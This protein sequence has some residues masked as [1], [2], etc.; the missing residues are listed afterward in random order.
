ML[1]AVK[2]WNMAEMCVVVTDKRDEK[3]ENAAPGGKGAVTEL[4][5]R[6]SVT[7]SEETRVANNESSPG[8]KQPN[9]G[10]SHSDADVANNKN[11]DNDHD[12]VHVHVHDN[13][14]QDASQD[15]QAHV[16]GAV[17]SLRGIID[18]VSSL[19]VDGWFQHPVSERDAPNYSAVI[20]NP[21]CFDMIRTKIGGL[22]Y[23]SWQEL[24]RDFELIFNN[25][26]LYNQKRSRVHK[27][28]LVLLR[29]GMK[30]LLD[31][32]T[33]GRS[34]LETLRVMKSG[35]ENL[36]A[37]C[38]I[39]PMQVDAVVDVAMRGRLADVKTQV[40]PEAGDDAHAPCGSDRK[41]VV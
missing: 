32:E 40:S 24:V 20:K 34:A 18:R 38:G 19:D 9:D 3:D 11:N 23:V 29:A 16:R 12:H 27:Q 17:G 37:M 25:A 14:V 33:E 5:K 28:A 21:M 22:R 2:Y 41:S 8:R 31:S 26:M 36:E 10:G 13:S 7:N 39:E 1:L 35:N 30:L 4:R 15:L 6:T